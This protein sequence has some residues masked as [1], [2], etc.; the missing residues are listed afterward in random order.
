MEEWTIVLCE[1]IKWNVDRILITGIGY[2]KSEGSFKNIVKPHM[3]PSIRNITNRPV[4]PFC[5]F[6]SLTKTSPSAFKLLNLQIII[7]NIVYTHTLFFFV[8][9]QVEQFHSLIELSKHRISKLL[10]FS[11]LF[12]FYQRNIGYRNLMKYLFFSRVLAN[13]ELQSDERLVSKR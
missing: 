9:I 11:S 4:R 1:L 13:Q 7:N 3:A 10:E 2:K 6:T 8:S 5:S 12:I